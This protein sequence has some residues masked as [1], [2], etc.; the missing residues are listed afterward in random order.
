MGWP[1]EDVK[2]VMT[3]KACRRS[4]NPTI[5]KG[6]QRPDGTSP[7]PWV[8]H[9]VAAKPRFSFKVSACPTF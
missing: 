4:E 9:Y 8:V 3:S 7:H 2:K 6:T 1:T 5:E